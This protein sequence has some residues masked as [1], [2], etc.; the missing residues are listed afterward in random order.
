MLY[1]L[2]YAIPIHSEPTRKNHPG[3]PKTLVHAGMGADTLPL[4]THNGIDNKVSTPEPVEQTHR[5][6]PATLQR[7]PSSGGQTAAHRLPESRP[8]E[9]LIPAHRR[10]TR[11]G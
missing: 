3:R 8:I 6:L 1:Q 2:S 4:R 7:G 11:A 9:I 10:Q 5:T